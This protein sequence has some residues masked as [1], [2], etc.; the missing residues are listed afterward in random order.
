MRGNRLNSGRLQLIISI[1]IF[2]VIAVIY[3]IANPPDTPSSLVLNSSNLLKIAAALIAAIGAA[4]PVGSIVN[5]LLDFFV[6]HTEDDIPSDLREKILEN[7]HKLW[8]AGA[9]RHSI[10]NDPLIVPYNEITDIKLDEESS[11]NKFRFERDDDFKKKIQ[12]RASDLAVEKGSSRRRSTASTEHRKTI[13]DAYVAS[14]GQ[15]VILGEGG[16]GK[17]IALLQLLQYLYDEAQHD[18]K[19]YIPV[20]FN[21]GSW[22]EKQLSLTEWLASELLNSFPDGAPEGL[23]RVLTYQVKRQKMIFLFDGLD[24]ISKMG[25]YTF[26]TELLKFSGKVRGHSIQF[27]ICS[28]PDEFAETEAD[29]VKELKKQLG[30]IELLLDQD[31]KDVQADAL[32]SHKEELQEILIDN[33]WRLNYKTILLHSIDDMAIRQYL[34]GTDYE[35][36]RKIIFGMDD[37]ALAKFLDART[38]GQ[39]R[40]NIR[41]KHKLYEPA[42]HPFIL[43][44]LA[45]GYK[46]PPENEVKDLE[47]ALNENTHM[48]MGA[49]LQPIPDVVLERYVSQRFDNAEAG[50]YELYSQEDTYDYLSWIV[51]KLDKPAEEKTGVE[52]K[53]IKTEISIEKLQ[54]TWLDSDRWQL[55]YFIVS[56]VLSTVAI[57]IGVGFILASPLDYLIAGM[58]A[59]IVIGILD[60]ATS[61]LAFKR[62][63]DKIGAGWFRVVRFLI[64][65]SLSWIT[66]SIFLGL[67][68]PAPSADKIFGGRIAIS[69]ITLAWF[70]SIFIA[71]IYITRE[72][73]LKLGDAEPAEIL[74]LEVGTMGR[75]A[76]IGGISIGAFVGAFAQVLLI[77]QDSSTATWLTGVIQS[78]GIGWLGAAVI[79]FLAG[80]FFGG[81]FA[82]IFGLLSVTSV[83]EYERTRPNQGIRKSLLNA[84][85]VGLSLT[86][87]F[88]GLFFLPLWF[89]YHDS[90]TVFRAIRNG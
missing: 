61:R 64:S 55:A 40:K 76:L 82:G 27:V 9:L 16:A 38:A 13:V 2:I 57:T 70:L 24:E 66:L 3:L 1:F 77:K 60:Y 83:Q 8:I 78:M 84:F 29:V 54:P 86:V 48:L 20:V 44:A 43:N 39:T 19:K 90:D 12:K 37:K 49:G 72:F 47:N 58:L 35:Y 28:R 51:Q 65:L 67:V 81:L 26:Y 17:T 88:S 25:R 42:H 87:V 85:R 23:S 59:G 18:S 89:T 5:S 6:K 45:V 50:D 33:K 7:Q 71:V 63:S 69:G 4:Q 11:V 75:Y 79:G 68:T 21:L 15:L 53:A 46:N 36:I 52:D 73:R 74:E 41:N 14:S 31:R 56:R 22:E 10:E 34:D 80:A 30:E 62:L 32:R